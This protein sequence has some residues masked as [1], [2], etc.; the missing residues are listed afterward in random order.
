MFFLTVFKLIFK[1][2]LIFA[3][4]DLCIAR[5]NGSLVVA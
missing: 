1:F 2:Y 3:G 4:G 5:L